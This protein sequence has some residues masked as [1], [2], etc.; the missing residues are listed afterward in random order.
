MSKTTAKSSRPAFVPLGTKEETRAFL[1]H[2][3]YLRHRVFTTRRCFPDGHSEPWAWDVTEGYELATARHGSLGTFD[4]SEHDV[5]L[6]HIL[7]RYPGLDVRYAISEADL[8]RPVLFVP[9]REGVSDGVA[10]GLLL[11]DGW[12]RL[13]RSVLESAETGEP[14][15]LSAYFLNE[16]EARAVQITPD[17]EPLITPTQP[18]TLALRQLSRYN[19]ARFR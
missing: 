8:S 11:I 3:S 10:A 14:R 5:G 4:P 18:G 19:I 15:P 7:T 17:A 1:L 9:W 12:H 16:D 2:V 6:A 13:F